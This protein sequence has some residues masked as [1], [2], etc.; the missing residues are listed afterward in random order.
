MRRDRVH[1]VGARPRSL[2]V[3]GAAAV[4]GALTP[5]AVRAQPMVASCPSG[6]SCAVFYSSPDLTGNADARDISDPPM[7]LPLG[8]IAQSVR[9]DTGR[10]L[11]LYSDPNHCTQATLIATVGP[12]AKLGEI[13]GDV[14]AYEAVSRPGS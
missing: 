11:S 3:L 6:A 2:A 10:P 7:C 5:T 9:N 8:S 13:P 14:R 4:V 12:G 1:A